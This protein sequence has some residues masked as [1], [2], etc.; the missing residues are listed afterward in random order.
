MDQQNDDILKDAEDIVNDVEQEIKNEDAVATDEVKACD[1]DPDTLAAL[2][3]ERADFLNYKT[4][5][6][7]EQTRARGFGKRDAVL[8][9]LPALDEIDRAYEHGDIE[10]DSPFDKIAQKFNEALDKLGV[11]SYGSKGDIFDPQIHQALMNRDA[12]D[13][14]ELADGEV[15]VDNV[16]AKGYRLDDDTIRT[17]T[18][19][20]VSK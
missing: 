16:V 9:I 11:R 2:A 15:K 5:A 18:V 10:E 19:T 17:A 1:H 12:N 3:R 14:D 20:T 13:A 8:G 6:E 7:K 4:R